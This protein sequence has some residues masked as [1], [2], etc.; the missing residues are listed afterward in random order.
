MAVPCASTRVLTDPTPLSLGKLSLS[1]SPSA[2]HRRSILSSF[3][4]HPSHPQ[5]CPLTFLYLAFK[6]TPMGTEIGNNAAERP[7]PTT[8]IAACKNSL[9]VLEF[10]LGGCTASLRNSALPSHHGL[11]LKR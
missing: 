4:A 11:L 9:T 7:M 3:I 1:N 6:H 8:T 2:L 10:P 5:L